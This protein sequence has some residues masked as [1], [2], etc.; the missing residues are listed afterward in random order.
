MESKLCECVSW[1]HKKLYSVLFKA[2]HV[3]CTL[4]RTGDFYSCSVLLFL[5]MTMVIFPCD[6]LRIMRETF[7]QYICRHKAVITMG[8]KP[9]DSWLTALTA[10][11]NQRQSRLL[12]FIFQYMQIK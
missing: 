5:T 4:S 10:G 2:I 9:R 7:L 3:H 6:P 12:H 8:P 1:M 11:R